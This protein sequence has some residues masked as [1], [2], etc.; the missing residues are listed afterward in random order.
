MI[1]LTFA[2]NNSGPWNRNACLLD[3][4]TDWLKA[5]RTK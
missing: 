3:W 5:T 1:I 2:H 4:L